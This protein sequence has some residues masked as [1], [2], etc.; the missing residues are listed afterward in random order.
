M[1][2]KPRAIQKEEFV[3]E[4]NRLKSKRLLDKEIAS[5]MFIS[6]NTLYRYKKE[7]GVPLI[8]QINKE[9]INANGLTREWL[10]IAQQNGLSSSLVNARIRDHH[11]SVEDACTIPTM[12]MGGKMMKKGKRK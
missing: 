7:Y 6:K 5:E 10:D 4:Y 11:W 2:G 9:L 3:E 12:P 1:R 8:T